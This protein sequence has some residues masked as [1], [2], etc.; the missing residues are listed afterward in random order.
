MTTINEIFKDY[1]AEYIK[2]NPKM[3]KH[4]R[5]VIGAIINCRSGEYGKTVFRCSDCGQ[6]HFIARSCGNRHC[7]LCQYHK[8]QKWLEKQLAKQ[9]PGHHF[10][11]TFTLPEEIRQMARQN[12]Q[13]VYQAMFKASSQAL[14]KLAKDKRFIGTN[15]P[16]FTGVLHTWGRQLQYHPHIHYVVAGGGLSDDRSKWI[17]SRK[18]F[19]I[20]IKPLSAI[21]RAIFMKEIKSA[22]LNGQI[23]SAVW[24]KDWVVDS[25]AVGAADNSICYLAPYVFRVAISNHRIV[26]LADGYVYFKY[27]KHGSRQIKTTRLKV[28]EFIRRFLQHVLPSGFMKVRH[29][30]FMNPNANISQDKIVRMIEQKTGEFLP[31]TKSEPPSRHYCSDCGGTLIYLWSILPAFMKRE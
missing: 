15:L 8:S 24:K 20:H 1:A 17:T 26:K 28:M 23:P 13:L 5:K 7:P 11:I 10:M 30:G 21:Y 29:Y 16:G 27:R 2:R 9:V 18:D 25:Q 12:Q 22:G 6:L 14:K 19:F 3:P 4:H 31:I